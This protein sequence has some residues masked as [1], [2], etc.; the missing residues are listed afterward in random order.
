MLFVSLK[1]IDGDMKLSL[2]ITDSDLLLE[3]DEAADPSVGG[4]AQCSCL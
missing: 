2:N 4:P 1:D 3:M